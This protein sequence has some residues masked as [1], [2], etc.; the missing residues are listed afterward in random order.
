MSRPVAFVILLTL[1]A[2]IFA[3]ARPARSSAPKN[4]WHRPHL[5][6]PQ[7]LVYYRLSIQKDRSAI[8]WLVSK[9]APRTRE[10][11]SILHWYRRALR[12]HSRRAAA[13]E[14]RLD[15]RD[16]LDAVRLVGRYFGAGVAAW[17][18]SCSRIGSEG[19]WG[20]WVSNTQ[21][22][23]AGGWLQFMPGTFNSVI[24]RAIGSARRRGMYVPS[25]ARSWHSP[26]GQALAG[27]Q[28][29]A[30]GRRNEWTG[31]GC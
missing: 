5:T 27:V 9:A 29:L 22:S 18:R 24:G 4:L 17:E 6:A 13:L 31:S 16:W 12:L 2:A 25:S 23:G 10:R 14:R 28:M 15:P 7:R 26:L 8:A 11:P 19:G 30:D 20:R 1:C 21:G 3:L